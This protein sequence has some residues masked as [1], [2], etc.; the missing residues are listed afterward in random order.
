MIFVVRKV[1]AL[2][3][4]GKFKNLSEQPKEIC[5]ISIHICILYMYIYTHT[6]IHVTEQ[7]KKICTLYIYAYCI[8]IYIHTLSYM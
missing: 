8:C 4:G 3:K 5:T 1:G 6:F 7:P 2:L